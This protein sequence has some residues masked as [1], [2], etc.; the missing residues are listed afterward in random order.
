MA[1]VCFILPAM[2]MVT[3][4]AWVYVRIGRLPQVEGLL[5]GVKPVIIAIVGRA[6]WPLACSA[7]RSR[8]LAVIGLT[9]AVLNLAGMNELLIL[10]GAGAIVAAPRWLKQPGSN[11]PS[12]LNA[13]APALGLATATSA[14]GASTMTF[15][16]GPLFLFFLKVGAVLF[17]SG[18]VLLAFLRA[19]LVERW[20]WLSEAQLLDA[21]AVGQITPGPVFTTATFIGY[22]LG[23]RAAFLPTGLRAKIACGL[24]PQRVNESL[25][26]IAPPPTHRR[27]HRP[28]RSRGS[29][30]FGGRVHA[31]E[32]RTKGEKSVGWLSQ[33]PDRLGRRHLPAA[34]REL[35]IAAPRARRR[36]H[37]ARGA[38]R[39]GAAAL[40][41]RHD[42]E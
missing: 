1:G 16:L 22:L 20:H 10:F 8:S 39:R 42:A 38:L 2:L 15:G 3:L 25:K 12:T 37:G 23:M 27:C 5:Y 31:A 36:L 29:P 13:A 14:A 35:P 17:G 28:H 41:H 4:L 30:C 32:G 6:L 9:A 21:I 18:Y 19:D 33:R 34:Q 11:D 26:V 24:P 7:V 40:D